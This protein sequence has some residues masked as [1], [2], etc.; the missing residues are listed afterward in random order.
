MEINVK[1]R[2]K[3]WMVEFTHGVQTFTLDYNVTKKDEAE[4]MKDRLAECFSNAFGENWKEKA[5]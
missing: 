2:G 1:K 5:D 3:I 4:W